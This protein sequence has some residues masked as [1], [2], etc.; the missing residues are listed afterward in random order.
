MPEQES[1]LTRS[2]D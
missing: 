1:I 2:F